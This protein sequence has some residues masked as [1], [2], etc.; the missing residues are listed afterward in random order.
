[1]T[2]E[3]KAKLDSIRAECQRAIDLAEKA[4]P[5]PWIV[6]DG[7]EFV[8]CRKQGVTFDIA[9]IQDLHRQGM[10]PNSDSDLEFIAH[11]RSF[12]PAAARAVLCIMETLE[13]RQH[14]GW[15]EMALQTLA[16]NWPSN[17]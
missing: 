12:T 14:E 3:L 2:T 9:V 6:E 15:V 16:D 5:G 13:Q 4:T 10:A 8:T 17:E 1:M 11:A 7:N